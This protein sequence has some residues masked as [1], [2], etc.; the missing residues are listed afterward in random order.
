[1]DRVRRPLLYAVL[2]PL[3]FA[4]AIVAAVLAAFIVLARALLG[5]LSARPI[6]PARDEPLRQAARAVLDFEYPRPGDERLHPSPQ[7][8]ALWT[9]LRKALVDE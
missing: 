7:G 8:A 5:R 4:A 2:V 9:R 1:M 6:P 3:S